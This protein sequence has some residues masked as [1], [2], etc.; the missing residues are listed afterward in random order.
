MKKYTKILAVAIAAI[1]TIG[2]I[3]F[4][5]CNKENNF[6]ATDPDQQTTNIAKT[7][8]DVILIAECEMSEGSTYIRFIAD[9][10]SF[11]LKFNKILADTLGDSFIL[12]DIEI[13]DDNV[14][15]IEEVP[16]LS[17]SIVNIETGIT[18]TYFAPIIKAFDEGKVLYY[19][20][21]RGH[22]E[23]ICR[24]QNCQGGCT[25]NSDKTGCDSKCNN[26]DGIC[27]TYVHYTD[28]GGDGPT[29]WEVSGVLLAALGILVTV[30][31]A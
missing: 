12:N 5:S 6:P 14:L 17:I 20:N 8:S 3:V 22:V 31:V 29:A 13:V 23:I 9:M 16:Y 4:V 26:Q 21:R 19:G 25:I 2:S 7:D 27:N 28:Q 10:D 30:L 1:M 11:E 18:S 15:D 24:G